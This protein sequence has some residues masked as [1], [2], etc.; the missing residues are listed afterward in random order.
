MNV[1]IVGASGYTGVELMRLLANHSGVR[2]TC[3]TSR[4]YAGQKVTTEFPSL[5]KCYE[6]VFDENDPDIIAAKAEIA[7]CALPHGTSM[8]VIPQLLERGVRVVD[9]SAD[10]RLHDLSTYNE[11]YGEH[12]SPELLAEAVY[13]LPEI[14]RK[15]IANARLVA[16]PGCYPTSAALALFPLLQAG[17]IDHRTLIVDSKSGTTGAGRS[18][19]TGNLFCEV[20]EGFKAY[21]V[22]GHRHTPE[23]EQTLSGVTGEPVKISFTPHLLPVDR[24]ILSTCYASLVKVCSRDEL[25]DIYQ[26]QYGGEPFVRVLDEGT[27]PNIGFVRGSNFCDVNLVVDERVGRV[28]A[29]AAIDNLVKGAS[30]QAIQNMNIMCGFDEGAGLSVVPLYP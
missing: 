15:A 18:L 20:N 30:G 24:G 16:N 27:L 10:Y 14:N 13:G 29:L 7:F 11:W 25:R 26:R 12:T 9:L 22:P 17:V 3:I 4:Q 28:V 8:E 1:A 21:G 23:I 6:G 19:K 2:V 5:A